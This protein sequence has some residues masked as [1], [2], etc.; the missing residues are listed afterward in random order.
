MMK[1]LYRLAIPRRNEQEELFVNF[2]KKCG[3]GVSGNM[4]KMKKFQKESENLKVVRK[5]PKNMRIHQENGPR[6]IS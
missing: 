4:Y 5:R 2:M 1:V 6:C 3:P